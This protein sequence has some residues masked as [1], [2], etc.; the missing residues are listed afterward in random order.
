MISGVTSEIY[1]RSTSQHQRMKT[2]LSLAAMVT[3]KLLL[4]AQKNGSCLI[5]HL[6]MTNIA[7]EAMAHR[8]RLFSQLETSICE[9]FSMAMLN[10]QIVYCNWK[11]TTKHN[12][13]GYSFSY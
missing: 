3:Y 1:I 7:M 4:M 13:I 10:N 5:Y 2:H 11:I 9:G 12:R 6:V 8:N